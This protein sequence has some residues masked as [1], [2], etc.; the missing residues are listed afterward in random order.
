MRR[1]TELILCIG[2]FLLSLLLV[3]WH[4]LI[5]VHT[6]E[7]KYL[8]NIPY[9]HPPFF[10]SIISWTEVLPF[11]E[12][13]WRLIFALLMV[14]AVWLVWDMTRSS[15]HL[16]DRMVV[17]AAWLLSAAVLTQAGTIMMAP[18]TALQ[19]LVFLWLRTRPEYCRRFPG[20]I[21][22]FWMSTLFTAYQGI[23]LL[24][25][26]WS[27]VRRGGMSRSWTMFFVGAPVALLLLYTMSNPLALAAMLIR[28]DQGSDLNLLMR[29]IGF[30]TLWVIGGS[31]IT[32]IVGTWGVLKSRDP[33]LILTFLLVCAFLFFSIAPSYYAILFAPL[34]AG[35]LY[36][37]FHDKKH[38]HA[39]P[40]LGSLIAACF[41][42]TWLARPDTEPLR[43]RPI[44][45]AAQKAG[46]DTSKTLLVSGSFGH[47]WQFES[48][49]PVRH[50]RP[51]LIEDAGMIVCSAKCEPMFNTTGWKL[52][53]G[54]L[55]ETWI[56][57]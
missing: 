38:P 35:G 18:V 33:A 1:R 32:S 44:V 47:E 46:L 40:I 9:P 25:L 17:C 30:G 3:Q 50:Y 41:V 27:A 11:Q 51:G 28:G 37:L 13:L 49:M 21:A 43:I 7:A 14:N 15:T 24:P 42:V 22:L 19:A 20:L 54:A 34:F 10:R 5:G 45:A 12:Y 55:V 6:D 8:L 4:A 53:P 56:R 31:F 29:V 57:K 23:L 26:A 52:A 2:F 16:Q 39:F 36:A 48:G